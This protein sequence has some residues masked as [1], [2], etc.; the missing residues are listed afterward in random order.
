MLTLFKS[1]K[2]IFNTLFKSTMR[3]HMTMTNIMK[4]VEIILSKHSIT[5]KNTLST[6]DI[7]DHYHR[8]ADTILSKTQY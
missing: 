2:Q 8:P 4:L 1:T 7:N 5:K 3:V 6:S